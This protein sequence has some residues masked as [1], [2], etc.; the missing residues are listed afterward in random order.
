MSCIVWSFCSGV[1]ARASLHPDPLQ[2]KIV[3]IFTRDKPSIYEPLVCSL[4]VGTDWW[5]LARTRRLILFSQDPPRKLAKEVF[6]RFIPGKE[7]HGFAK[8]W[9]KVLAKDHVIRTKSDR[10]FNTTQMGQAAKTCFGLARFA[11]QE[12]TKPFPVHFRNRPKSLYF[13]LYFHLSS[14]NPPWLCLTST[15]SQT[16]F[17]SSLEDLKTRSHRRGAMRSTKLNQTKKIPKAL[18]TYLDGWFPLFGF[19][20]CL[21]LSVLKACWNMLESPIGFKSQKRRM[22]GLLLSNSQMGSLRNCQGQGVIR[23]QN[24]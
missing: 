13:H 1:S 11:K 6:V 17:L 8:E 5:R 7:K 15:I 12:L 14:T 10:V 2:R 16:N 3:S 18:N 9:Q 24:S 19:W 20:S 22:K 4:G 23:C 21:G